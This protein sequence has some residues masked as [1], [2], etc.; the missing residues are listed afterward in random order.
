MTKLNRRNFLERTAALGGAGLLTPAALQGAE[1][2]VPLHSPRMIKDDISLAQWALVDEVRAGKWKTT[3]FAK[4]AKEDFGLSGIEYVNTLMEV[5]TEG[6]L[7]K[8]KKNA[9]DHGVTN[10]LIMVDDEGDG[11][12]HTKEGRKQFDIN[13]RKW[14]DAAH[15]LGCHAIRT[16]CRGSQVAQKVSKEESLKWA[17]DSY[18]MLLEYAIPAK[19][20]VVIENHGGLSNDPDWMV[21]LMKEVDNLY[22]GTYPDWREPS[23]NFDNVEYLK[24]TLPYAKGMSYRN[25]PTEELSAKMIKLSRDAGYRGWYGIESSGR[26][27]IK[28]GKELLTKYL[29]NT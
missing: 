2:A 3:E 5:P 4:V 27:E 12:S 9:E 26:E 6:Y 21:A 8:L 13:H 14:I 29:F 22:F 19:I 20:L 11:C 16:N 23:A 10:V 1:Q 25:Q 24:K 15:Y 7:K 18:N 28:K 17:A